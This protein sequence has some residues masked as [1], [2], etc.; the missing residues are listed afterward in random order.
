[1]NNYENL[2]Q[3]TVKELSKFF[4]SLSDCDCCPI[5]KNKN[6]CND[7]CYIQYEKWLNQEA[8]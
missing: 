2:Q 1:M 8:K 4:S 3:M 7:F 5:F 6:K